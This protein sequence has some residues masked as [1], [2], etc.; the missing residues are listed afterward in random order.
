[1]EF[2]SPLAQLCIAAILLL[3]I[4]QKQSLLTKLTTILSR[5]I[6]VSSSKAT[7]SILKNGDQFNS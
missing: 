5:L 3:F 6:N 1:M 2:A 7:K 4:W